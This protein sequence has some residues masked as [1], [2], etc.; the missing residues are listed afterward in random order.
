MG[1]PTVIGP[2]PFPGPHSGGVPPSGPLPPSGPIPPSGPVFQ[3]A[4]LAPS[5]PVPGPVVTV[6]PQQRSSNGALIATI[7]IVCV[8]AL[9]G[10]VGFFVINSLRDDDNSSPDTVA[11]PANNDGSAGGSDPTDA[12]GYSTYDDY[13]SS[14]NTYGSTSPQGGT[15]WGMV[16]SPEGSLYK[17]GGYST[18]DALLA[19]AES[20][21]SFDRSTWGHVYFTDGCGA[22][23]AP[24]S[25]TTAYSYA[26]GV[27]SSRSAAES[28]AIDSSENL[29]RGA[30]SQ[31]V[32][33]LCVG[34]TI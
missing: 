7:A 28:A 25:R 2:P 17:F 30:T 16:I 8:V 11:G 21:Y 5:G 14:G 10:V 29:N 19:A 18:P 9:L 12:S 22:F 3:G 26:Y 24:Y 13:G 32:D 31:A 1:P 4:P 20:R 27:G 23:A 34:D 15:V 33:A 6:E